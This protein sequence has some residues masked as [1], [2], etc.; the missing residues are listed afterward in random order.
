MPQVLFD[1]VNADKLALYIA[2]TAAIQPQDPFCEPY[3]GGIKLGSCASAG[4]Q[5]KHTNEPGRKITWAGYPHGENPDFGPSTAFIEICIKGCGCCPEKGMLYNPGAVPACGAKPALPYCEDGPNSYDPH[6][7][8]LKHEWCGV[9][10]PMLNE[11]RFIDFYFA[12][13]VQNVCEP[14]NAAE[15]GGAVASL[16]HVHAAV[17]LLG[18]RTGVCVARPETDGDVRGEGLLLHLRLRAHVQLGL[19][20][21]QIRKSFR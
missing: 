6:A 21:V 16:R 5:Y 3:E 15:R 12:H 14:R 9:C 18:S 4:F 19:C 20:F 8:P 7:L 13:K 1:P 10:G 2:F 11:P 17:G